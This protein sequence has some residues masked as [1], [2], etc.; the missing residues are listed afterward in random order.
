MGKPDCALDNTMQ[1]LQ[2]LICLVTAL[3]KLQNL[4]LSVLV[5]TFA[6]IPECCIF[7]DFSLTLCELYKSVRPLLFQLQHIGKVVLQILQF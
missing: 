2:I 6:K 4:I 5:V 7:N 1:N 3:R